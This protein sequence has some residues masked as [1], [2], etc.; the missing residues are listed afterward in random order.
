M[1]DDDMKPEE[2]SLAIDRAT[3]KSSGVQRVR[4]KIQEMA[5]EEKGLEVLA[6]V[7]RRMLRE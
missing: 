1:A 6:T 3:A 4:A 5:T 2:A 7:I